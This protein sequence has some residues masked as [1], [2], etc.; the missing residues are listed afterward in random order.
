M[1]L[2]YDYCVSIKPIDFFRASEEVDEA[3]A[4]ALAATILDMGRWQAP[5]P[6]EAHSGIVMDGNHRI[7]AA[8]LLGLRYLPCVLLGYDD[9]RVAVHDWHAGTVFDVERIR[10]TLG[11]GRLLAYKTTRHSFDPPLPRTDIPLALLAGAG[12]GAGVPPRARTV[13]A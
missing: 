7:R 8:A 6:V 13:P 9:A 2:S 3:M 5:L 4:H 11:D 10:R 1:A 12:A